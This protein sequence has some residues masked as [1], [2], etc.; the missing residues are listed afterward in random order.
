MKIPSEDYVTN[1]AT[2]IPEV[3]QGIGMA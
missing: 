2:S 1:S 3:N